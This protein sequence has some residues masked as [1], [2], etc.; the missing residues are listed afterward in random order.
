[1]LL[2]HIINWLLAVV[3]V[4][5]IISG[6][7]ITQFRVITPLTLGFLDKSQSFWLHSSLK[8][9]FILLFILH[10]SLNI[11]SREKKNEE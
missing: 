1:M 4:L 8:Y 9:P 2:Q 7:G 5:L 6:F 11:K 3:A 10:V